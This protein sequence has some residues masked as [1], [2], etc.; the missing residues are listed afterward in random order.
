MGKSTKLWLP[1]LSSKA[2]SWRIGVRGW[3]FND[4]KK[5]KPQLYVEEIDDSGWSGRTDITS[6]PLI[7]GMHSR[8]MHIE[9]KYYWWIQKKCSNHE[10]PPE[11][12]KYYL[13]G[14]NQTQ[15]RSLGLMIWKVMRRN[16]WKDVANWRIRRLSNCIK[17]LHHVVTNITSKRKTWKG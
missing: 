16:A 11:Q 17:S 12:M 4:W 8:W 7:L 6:W 15:T 3:R 2:R 10:S 1:V 14:R 5:T 9:R 13:V